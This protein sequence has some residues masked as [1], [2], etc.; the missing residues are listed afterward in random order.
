MMI[1]LVGC[2]LFGSGQLRGGRGGWQDKGRFRFCVRVVKSCLTS[3]GADANVDQTGARS[4]SQI[5]KTFAKRTLWT[6]TPSSSS[7]CLRP[8][9]T[10]IFRFQYEPR[11]NETEKERAE[12]Q[13][14]SADVSSDH[15]LPSAFIFSGMRPEQQLDN[16]IPADSSSSSSS[17]SASSHNTASKSAQYLLAEPSSSL[18]LSH[19][20]LY[21]QHHARCCCCNEEQNLVPRRPPATTAA[22]TKDHHYLCHVQGIGRCRAGDRHVAPPRGR[23]RC[24]IAICQLCHSA[25]NG[26]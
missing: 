1:A 21:H 11:N 9:R 8:F 15:D 26:H 4:A 14:V 2:I 6:P 23:N 10:G 3:E 17:L 18:A 12:G 16:G 20:H 7:L 13:W 24:P 25:T 5:F 19:R 22:T